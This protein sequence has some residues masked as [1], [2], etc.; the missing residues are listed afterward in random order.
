[1]RKFWLIPVLVLAFGG[2]AMAQEK[3]PPAAKEKPAKAK[4]AKLMADPA[5][6]DLG[7]VKAGETKD[8]TVTI[9]NEGEAEA[10]KV[11]CKGTGFKFEGDPK[12]IAGGAS[13]Q[14]KG[15]YTAAKKAAKKDKPI[16]GTIA[17]GAAKVPVKGTLKAA[18]APAT[19]EK[20]AAK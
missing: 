3:A 2:Y 14:F 19:P 4:P 7:E 16:K 15:V 10:K 1:M 20:P 11:A 18:E 9:K 5:E 13:E 17:C 8:V 12:A 6:V